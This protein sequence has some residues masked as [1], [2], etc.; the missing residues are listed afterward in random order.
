MGLI[1]RYVETEQGVLDNNTGLIWQKEAVD[2]RHGKVVMKYCDEE[3][4]LR[5]VCDH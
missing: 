3:H 5:L 4:A 1:M 2:F